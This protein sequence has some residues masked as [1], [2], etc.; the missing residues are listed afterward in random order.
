MR[1][2]GLKV[3]WPSHLSATHAVKR[4]SAI[5]GGD[6]V[7][8]KYILFI[9]WENLAMALESSGAA[10]YISD[11]DLFIMQNGCPVPNLTD[12]L[13][14]AGLLQRQQGGAFC[15][16]FSYYNSHLDASYLPDDA[17]TSYATFKQS[18]DI[19]TS[20]A[21]SVVEQ[22][23]PL[24]WLREDGTKMPPEALKECVLLIKTLDSILGLGRRAP[25]EF[26]VGLIAAASRLAARF[27]RDYIEVVLLR[28]FQKK[29]SALGFPKRVSYILENFD[30]VASKV[31]PPNGYD[32]WL[33]THQG[34]VQEG[35]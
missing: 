21:Y 15:P 29:G 6:D 28:M 4:L 32:K 9:L 18:Q 3:S 7:R 23:D 34:H 22:L 33:A 30:V 26:D 12:K 11:A 14:A 35:R 13:I 8:V 24:A 25:A 1:G 27:P 17:T 16:M 2:D 19:L 31:A 10:G 5:M 20:A